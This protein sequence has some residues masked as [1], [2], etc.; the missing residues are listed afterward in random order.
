MAARV[1]A[2]PEVPV[3]TD[4]PAGLLE[5]RREEGLEVD[6]ALARVDDVVQ[7]VRIAAARVLLAVLDVEEPVAV[8]VR[9]RVVEQ[10]IEGKRPL[11]RL[12]LAD[13]RPVDVHFEE[14]EAWIRLGEQDVLAAP[15]RI[16]RRRRPLLE[17]VVEVEADAALR[18]EL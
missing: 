10:R 12:P 9:D 2:L 17:V 5:Q 3:A 16:V 6:V 15:R 14:D 13:V 11:A 8:A 4:L 18:R 7:R 1:V